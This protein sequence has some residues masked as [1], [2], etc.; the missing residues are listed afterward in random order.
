M[1]GG[2]CPL[3]HRDTIELRER[4]PKSDT[5]AVGSHRSDSYFLNSLSDKTSPADAAVRL[6]I[7]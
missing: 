3:I 2:E 4:D 5:A 7:D 6:M 1:L